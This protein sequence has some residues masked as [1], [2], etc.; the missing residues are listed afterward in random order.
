MKMELLED[1]ARVTTVILQ[2]SKNGCLFTKSYVLEPYTKAA[3]SPFTCKR[4]DD[5]H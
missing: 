4:N 5:K 2:A 1:E 3:E